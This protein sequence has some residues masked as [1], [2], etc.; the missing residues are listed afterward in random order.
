MQPR[1]MRA[2]DFLAPREAQTVEVLFVAVIVLLLIA[3]VS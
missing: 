1:A 3:C 2:Q